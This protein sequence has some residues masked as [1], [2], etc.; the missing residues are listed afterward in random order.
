MG[1]LRLDQLVVVIHE[2][3]FRKAKVIK[4]PDDEEPKYEVSLYEY[5]RTGKKYEEG[6][7]T[8]SPDIEQRERSKIYTAGKDHQELSPEAVAVAKAVAVSGSNLCAARQDRYQVPDVDV[9]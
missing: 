7:D 9:F 6:Y 3:E 2:G 4:L 1:E 5:F 8:R